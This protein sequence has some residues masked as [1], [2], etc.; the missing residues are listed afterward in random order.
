MKITAKT[1][2]NHYGVSVDAVKYHFRKGR[3]IKDFKDV[4]TCI[5]FYEK[6]KK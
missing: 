2:A 5:V 1:I 6:K 3:S 4:V